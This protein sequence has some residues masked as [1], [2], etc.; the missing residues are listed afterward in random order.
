L[1]ETAKNSDNTFVEDEAEGSEKADSNEEE[2]Y[3]EEEYSDEDIDIE[4]EQ[5]DLDNL[6]RNFQ[7]KVNMSSKP[8][9]TPTKTTI[10]PKAKKDDRKMQ[11]FLPTIIYAYVDSSGQKHV[12]V[13]VLLLS[14]MN[15]TGIIPKIRTCGQILDFLVEIP[16]GFFQADRLDLDED[17]VKAASLVQSAHKIMKAHGQSE[18]GFRVRLTH[19]VVLPFQV[20]PSFSLKY[21][22]MGYETIRFHAGNLSNA[23]VCSVDLTAS[24]MRIEAAMS[25]PVRDFGS[26]ARET[27]AAAYAA[28]QHMETGTGG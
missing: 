21:S 2:D 18:D 5:G 9:A 12:S 10:G 4:S 19:S 3:E 27:E 24:S 14:G 6:S 11:I 13:D 16:A 23:S 8:K 17:D 25:P 7:G 1:T 26:L 22:D 20:R 28:A 15:M